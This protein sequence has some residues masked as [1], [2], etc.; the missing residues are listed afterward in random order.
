MSKKL[1]SKEN[2]G[3]PK[4]ELTEDEEN[5]V[6]QLYHLGNSVEDI[7]TKLF[8]TKNKVKIVINEYESSV[9]PP[10]M[11]KKTHYEPK[12]HIFIDPRTQKRYY[13]VTEFFLETPFAVTYK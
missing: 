6:I 13:D 8:I 1:I 10:E 9:K 7:A 2:T 3:L 12:V 11:L 4:R 5:H